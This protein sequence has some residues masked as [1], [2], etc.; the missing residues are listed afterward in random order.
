MK[1]FS[2]RRYFPAF[3]TIL[4]M[5]T[6]APTLLA[7]AATI[8]GR[9][10]SDGGQ[11]IENANAVISELN[12]SVGSNAQG[13]YSIV[14]PGE[15]VRGQSVTL[16]I[17]AIG[18][19][20]VTRQINITAG[21]QTI[22]ITMARD[23]NRLQ[24]VIVTGVTAGTEQKKTPFTV[25]ALNAEQDL[26]V[27]STNALAQLA[28]K[29]PGAT[30]RTDGGRPGTAPSI[31]LRGPHS[32]NAS[33]RSQGPLILVDGIILNGGT[34]DLNPEDI[35]TIEVVKGAAASSLYGSRAGNGIISITTKSARNQAPGM[36]IGV[37]QEQG[38][39]VVNG[40]YR[41][42]RDHMLMM[43]EDNSRFCIQQSGLPSCS[44]TV[45]MAQEA[46]RINDQGGDASLTPY[47][48][49][50]DFGIANAPKKPELKGLFMSNLWPVMYNPIDQAST[51]NP[52]TN[53]S[54]D[55][56]GKT[57]GTS[58]FTSFNSLINTGAI[59]FLKGY[60]RQSA[61]VNVD[62]SITSDLNMSI[63]TFFSRSQNYS[64][65]EGGNNSPYF[66]LTRQHPNT[67]LLGTDSKG[68]I[69]VRPDP[70]AETSQNY[71]PLYDN[72]AVYGRTNVDRFLG[73][74]TTRYIASE[75]LN[76]DG[77]ASIDNRRSNNIGQQDKGYRTTVVGPA[78][79]GSIDAGAGTDLS[80]NLALGATAT[81][82]FGRDLA[83][84]LNLRYTY[85]DQESNDNSASGNTL[86]VPGLLTLNNATASLDGSYSQSSVRALGASAGL[87]LEY[88]ERYIFD[89]A[90]RNDG[91]SLFG[92]AQR[93]HS[94]YRG[95]V[96][97]R[98]SDEPFWKFTDAIN[99]LKLRAAVGT[100]GGRP[101]F[102][103]QYEAFSIGTGGAITATTLGN[104]ELRPEVTLETEYGI[105]AELFHRYGLTLTYAR[106][107]TT[108]EILQVP[109]SVSSGF[110]SQWLNA[111]TMDGRTWE[112]S[113]NVPILTKRN[114]VWTSRINWDQ[115]RSVIT[116][117]DVPDF[118]QSV[119]NARVHYAVG[120]RYGNI[121]GKKFATSC[122]QLPSD[123]ASQ[124]G[125]GQEWQRNSDGYIVWVG[126]GNTA[127]DGITKNLWQAQRAGCIVKGVA[128]TDI[129]GIK[130]CL[131]AGGTV[132]NP[133]GQPVVNWG[134]LQVLRDSTGNPA[135]QEMGNGLP[136]WKASL[137]QNFQY[138]RLN[139]YALFE[140]SFGSGVFNLDRHWSLGDF[141]T[142][143]EDQRGKSIGDAKPIGYYWRAPA[144]D[145]PA[146]VGG[147]YDVLG[148]NSLT[149]EDG[150]FTKFRELSASYNVGALPK[151][152][153]DW[154]IIV[155]GRNLYTWTKY[156]GWDP[157]VGDTGGNVNSGAAVAIQAFQYPSTRTFVL[158]LSSK[159]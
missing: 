130:D 114:L 83:S 118:F 67:N 104:K 77:S 81:H 131:K 51:S 155:V 33:G 96:A 12:I 150:G 45:D 32:I 152:G 57:G 126:Q 10:L 43:S 11:P 91:S 69:Y 121:W 145:N 30:I 29:V 61:R 34:T 62:Q 95:S 105:D 48:F 153:G 64:D 3:A 146:G 120:E 42:A 50:R 156:T 49:E 88:K 18:H 117:M 111:G 59:K 128:H 148:P 68:R 47:I 144:P 90:L 25:T 108:D 21:T 74:M 75:W 66:T 141:M 14:I 154:S 22:D 26:Q 129:T 72:Q 140:K 107:I 113:L 63:Q 53:T 127:S 109:P 89:G 92:A 136:L 143:D 56:S 93:W 60:R 106:D 122:S 103:A 134:M 6:S 124:C 94:Y 44:R 119:D 82:N 135:L 36:R 159:F 4:A 41:F 7:Q 40:D 116:K 78:N 19:L 112:A 86:A 123:F 139:V 73:S 13:R 125:P 115:N 20:A 28:G 24:E 87:N 16:R 1:R 100:A 80:Y 85:E 8:T 38:F 151:I 132:N 97:W 54:L 37:K 65:G 23:I 2:L 31:L 101:R 133:W 70:T 110:S 98:L 52:Y 5:A 71:N 15:R 142:Q 27:P 137:A 79:L 35:E 102:S 138:K 58:Y 158:T 147:F 99:D 76:F 39:S 55:I 17:R 157:D 46:F 149:F 9:V 84:R